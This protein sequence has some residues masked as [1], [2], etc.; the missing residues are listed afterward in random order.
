MASC[1]RC[2]HLIPGIMVL[3]SHPNQC[4]DHKV[5]F[6]ALS[7]MQQQ[8][9]RKTHVSKVVSPNPTTQRTCVRTQRLCVRLAHDPTGT[10]SK[11][12]ALSG[13]RRK[14]R[15]SPISG[16]RGEKTG[17]PTGFVQTESWMR[18]SAVSA[19]QQSAFRSALNHSSHR[20][21]VTKRFFMRLCRWS[22][23]TKQGHAKIPSPR[24]HLHC[25]RE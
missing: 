9:R 5:E 14:Q 10:I 2:M 3:L 8:Y 12:P 20:T 23:G 11:Y 18:S 15:D 1:C 21:K 6:Q 24:L 4:I 19:W 13:L 22:V 25:A 16:C 17:S 7:S